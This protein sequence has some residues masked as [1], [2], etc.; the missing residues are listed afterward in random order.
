MQADS[1]TTRVHGGLGLGLAIA[2][3]LIEMHG[4]TIRAE[5]DGPN[6]GS[7]FTVMLPAKPTV[8]EAATEPANLVPIDALASLTGLHILA[9]DDS[10]DALALVQ[11]TLES[12]GAEVLAVSSVP[13]ALEQL[14]IRRPDVLVADIGMP[15]ADG[16]S[17]IREIRL[18]EERG[19]QERLPAIAL[20]AYARASDRQ[21]AATAGFDLHLSKPL[22]PGALV[23]AI[24]GVTAG[25]RVR[26]RP[27]DPQVTG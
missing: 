14:S 23:Q 16:Y 7:T 2:R 20:T 3:H 13:D 12:A 21:R 27:A 8:M 4:G 24:R 6:L 9:V 15:D 17:L 1:T 10:D 19:G 22:D 5:S 26:G 18:M 25:S 11:A